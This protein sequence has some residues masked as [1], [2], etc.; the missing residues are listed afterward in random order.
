VPSIQVV[1]K[2]F[3]TGSPVLRPRVQFIIDRLA[4]GDH[5]GLLRLGRQREG[6]GE[7]K[8]SIANKLSRGAF[9]ATFFLASLAEIGCENIRMEEI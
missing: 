8:A 5:C 9:T 7:T 1:A 6:V 2:G 4:A 3:T